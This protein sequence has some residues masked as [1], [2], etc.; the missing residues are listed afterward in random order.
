MR[1]DDQLG[2]SDS[3][4]RHDEC[5]R[6]W[7]GGSRAHTHEGERG[8]WLFPGEARPGEAITEKQENEES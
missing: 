2:T 1:Q 7:L 3:P 4:I 5:V 6:T 8:Y